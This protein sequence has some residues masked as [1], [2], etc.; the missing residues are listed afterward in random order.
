MS[1]SLPYHRQSIRLKDY[2]YSSIGYYYITLCTNNRL[3]I[4]GHIEN[5][6]VKLSSLGELAQ[7]EWVNL[8]NRYKNIV[9]DEYIIMPNHI[10]GIIAI[11]HKSNIS[12]GDIICGYK[13]VTTRKYNKANN[14]NGTILWQRNYYEHIIRNEKELY[15]IQQYIIYNPLKWNSDN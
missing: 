5:N 13:S 2:D 11:E 14:C 6:T 1:N 7:K 8:T 3:N 10:H 4:L 9:L 12:I 15:K